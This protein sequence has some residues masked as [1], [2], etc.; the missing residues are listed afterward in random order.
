MSD[1]GRQHGF[2]SRLVTNAAVV[3]LASVIAFTLG[4]WTEREKLKNEYNKLENERDKA[5]IEIVNLIKGNQTE[6]VDYLL[7]YYDCKY[8]DPDRDPDYHTLLISFSDFI[9]SARGPLA[10]IPPIAN[11]EAVGI[12]TRSIKAELWSANRR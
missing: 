12:S 8:G 9:A 6:L 1:P 3:A 5:K 11:P 7:L 10:D 2:W 4:W